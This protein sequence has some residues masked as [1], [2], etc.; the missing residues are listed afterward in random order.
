ME[1]LGDHGLAEL[2]GDIVTA[3]LSVRRAATRC[4]CGV[5]AV[6]TTG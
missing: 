3:P 6:V 4:R 1:E 2:G 5:L